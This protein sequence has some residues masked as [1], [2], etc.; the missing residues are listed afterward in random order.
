M[1][2]TLTIL[3]GLFLGATLSLQAADVKVG[4][5]V[6]LQ[7]PSAGNI[8]VAAGKLHA[9]GAVK[10]DLVGASGEMT[11]NS[12]IEQDA[13]LAGGK[14]YFN[15]ES[16][17]DVRIVGGEV[18]VNKNIKGDLT[19]TGGEIRIADGV[20]IGGDLIVGGGKVTFF[21]KVLGNV[22]IAGGKLSL[23]GEVQGNLISKA[24]YLYINAPINGTSNIAAERLEL[25]SKAFF[26]SA[27]QYWAKK[28]P[29]FSGKT[30]EGVNVV[31]N[32]HLK[33]GWAD[34]EHKFY[35]AAHK[36]QRGYS[37]IRIFSG[38]LMVLLLI[39]FGDKFFSRYA[40]QAKSNLGP[41]LG[42]G[43]MLMIGLPLLSGLAF[44]TVIGIPVGMIGF[45][46]YGIMMSM[47]AALPAVIGAYEWRK[48]RQ[49]NWTR[50][51]VT[52]VALGIF[53]V[54]R[55]VTNFSFI[56][57]IINFVA[58]TLAFGYIYLIIRKKVQPSAVS[59]KDDNEPDSG[60]LV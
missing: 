51:G 44:L 15:A 12:T 10:G 49:E 25:G 16:N 28:R 43:L 11:V 54:L 59:D 29:D 50:G 21:G 2:K 36:M 5:N 48:L 47:T 55:F 26:G 3:S 22:H 18:I 23:E 37:V 6:H 13:L 20:V 57:G 40:G 53:L 32:R 7:E 60:D 30:G 58:A 45:G 27:V 8:Y 24:G 1:K 56:G 33:P 52:L 42:L 41:S 14:V 34:A 19:I 38:L 31:F 39:A 17:G 9:Q 46:V 4:E 35:D